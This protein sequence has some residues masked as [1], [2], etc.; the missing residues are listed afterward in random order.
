MELCIIGV[1][2]E[3]E[4]NYTSATGLDTVVTEVHAHVQGRASVRAMVGR[5]ED[6]ADKTDTPSTGGVEGN[7][8]FPPTGRQ[9]LR[10]SPDCRT[11]PFE[12]PTGSETRSSGPAR[13]HHSAYRLSTKQAVLARSRPRDSAARRNMPVPSCCSHKF[14]AGGRSLN[15]ASPMSTDHSSVDF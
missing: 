13:R 5:G 14:S 7:I 3:S 4:R 12:L 1:N 10:Q 9:R 2:F 6:S 8:C 11:F 15:N